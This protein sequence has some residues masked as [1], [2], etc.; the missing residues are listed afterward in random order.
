[1]KLIYEITV[2]SLSFCLISSLI[3]EVLIRAKRLK[4]DGTYSK[5]RK[6]LHIN[7]QNF[8]FIL[9]NNENKKSNTKP[10]NRKKPIKLSTIVSLFKCLYDHIV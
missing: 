8:A 10:Q 1:M 5:V 6:I 7:F 2:F 9:F 3:G 4:K